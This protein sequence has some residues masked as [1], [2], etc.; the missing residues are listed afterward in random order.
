MGKY[1]SD[2]NLIIG[3]GPECKTCQ[4]P[5][6]VM[7]HPE[8][9]EPKPNKGWHEYW[10]VCANEQCTTLTVVAPNSFRHTDKEKQ[11]KFNWVSAQ[12]AAGTYKPKA[13][14]QAT[15]TASVPQPTAETDTP[16]WEEE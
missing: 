7:A 9:W 11:R 14:A 15:A 2:N 8:G 10:Y 1:N 12:I 13:Q 4:Q 5:M 6:K 16:P 3:T